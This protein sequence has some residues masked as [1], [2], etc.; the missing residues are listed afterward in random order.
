MPSV[1]DPDTALLD[2]A[3]DL[4]TRAGELLARGLGRA[5]T[6][7]ATKSS[8][9]DMV[10]DMDRAAEDLVVQGLA[11]SRPGDGVLGEEGADT[12]GTTGVRWVVDPLD[13]TTNYL[14]GLP[15]F[16]VSI[17]AERDGRPTLGVVHDPNRS[18]TFTALSGRGAWLNGNRLRRAVAPSLDRALIGTGFGYDPGRRRAQAALLP[19]VL[20][21]VRDIRRVGSAAID[22]CWVGA[23]RLDAFYEAGLRPWDRAAGALVAAESGATV[24]D[25]DGAPDLPPLLVAAAPG[26]GPDLAAL[27]R[28]ALAAGP[29]S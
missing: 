18:E 23:G 1:P 21:A 19:T 24:E 11:R 8:P 29:T 2:L 17:A 5:R 20:P 22:L 12:A 27:L 13:G 26:L 3:V 25:L 6:A 14:Y 16:A 4:A 28:C 9:T 7:V 15:A 10:S